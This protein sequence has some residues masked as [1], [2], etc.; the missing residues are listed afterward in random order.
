MSLS[1]RLYETVLRFQAKGTRVLLALQ[2][3]PVIA[4]K[5]EAAG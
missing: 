4:H 3:D 5:D 2:R 1:L